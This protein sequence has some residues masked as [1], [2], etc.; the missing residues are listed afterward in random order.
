ME[1]STESFDKN[2]KKLI[3]IIDKEKLKSEFNFNNSYDYYQMLKKQ[4][5]GKNNSWAI[6]WYASAFL[7]KYVDFLSLKNLRKKYRD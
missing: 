2:G 3:N 6:R 1:E 5:K 7:K 4:I